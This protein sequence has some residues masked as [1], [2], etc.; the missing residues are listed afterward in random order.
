MLKKIEST[1]GHPAAENAAADLAQIKTILTHALSGKSCTAY[2]FGSRAAG[3]AQPASD[4]DIAV[5]A[6]VDISRE[7][8]VARAML[9]ESNFPFK[10]DVVDLQFVA[11]SF[12]HATLIQGVLLWKT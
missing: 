2:L 5:L 8:S 11:P 3:T 9:D 10:V 4:F 12:R 7:L 6:D 1:T